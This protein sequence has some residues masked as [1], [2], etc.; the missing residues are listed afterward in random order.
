MRD[1]KA[2][3]P[4]V[5]FPVEEFASGTEVELVIRPVALCLLPL[6]GSNIFFEASV[7]ESRLLGRM[8]YIHLSS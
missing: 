3:T 1:N 6:E 8:S 4:L 7:V 2:I 5:D